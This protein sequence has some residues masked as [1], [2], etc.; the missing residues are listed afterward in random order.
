[1]AKQA[2]AKAPE[3]AP[4]EIEVVKQTTVKEVKQTTAPSWE[5]KDRTYF[6]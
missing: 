2:T 6:Y 3:V 4:Q 5:I 1:M